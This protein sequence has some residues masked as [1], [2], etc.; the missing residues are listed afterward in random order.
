MTTTTVIYVRKTRA[1]ALRILRTTGQAAKQGGTA[2]VIL[3][4]AGTAILGRIHR[5]FLI[6]SRGGTDATGARWAPLSPVTVAKR[7]RKLNPTKEED[8]PSSALTSDQR[9]LWWDLYRRALW[10]F[11]VKHIAAR[12]AWSKLRQTGAVGHFDKYGSVSVGILRDT[13]AL[14]KSLDPDSHS[15]HSIFRIRPG[16]A[17]IGTNRKGASAHH[18]GSDRLPQRRLWPEVGRWTSGWWQEVLT[19]GRAGL[20]QLIIARLA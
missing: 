9:K 6:K 14:L 19:E 8:R 13:E 11:K 15:P 7:L 18:V 4:K 16:M 20:T 3:Q 1:E 12:V 5:A 10:K 2:D 17:E